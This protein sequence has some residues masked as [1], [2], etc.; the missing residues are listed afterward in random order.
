MKQRTMP[1][2]GEPIEIP[3]PTREQFFS[4][5]HKVALVDPD[6]ETDDLPHTQPN[7]PRKDR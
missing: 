7:D 2:F 1:A 4:D 3:V 6:D 5:L